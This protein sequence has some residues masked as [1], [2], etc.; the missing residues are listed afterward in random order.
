MTKASAIAQFLGKPLV[1]SDVTI[2]SACSMNQLRDNAVLFLTKADDDALAQINAQAAVLCIASAAAAERL[3][4]PHVVHDNPRLAFCQVLGEFFVTTSTGGIHPS[5]EISASATLAD[6]VSVG[7]GSV[8]GERVRI[9][10]DTVIGKH[11][12]VE[13]DVTIGAGC[14]LRS[15]T[16]IGDRGFGFTVDEHKIPIPFPHLGTVVIEDHV[17]LG[18]H[19]TVARAAL[20]ATRIAEYVKTDDHV[21]IAHN[22]SVGARTFIAAG[23][24][25]SGSVSLGE[26]VWIGP[27]ATIADYVS[28]GPNARIG[29]GA[30][31]LK[32]VPAEKTAIG[33]PARVTGKR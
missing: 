31:V 17:E 10:A 32:S 5:V 12:V 3:V 1:G 16:V 23:A 6:S 8:I 20:D 29:I 2:L 18:A 25:L 11:V 27:N 4:V 28:V 19:N 33:N 13:N 26:D 14:V 24:V 30:V 9:G 21:H 15:H 7:A 22:C